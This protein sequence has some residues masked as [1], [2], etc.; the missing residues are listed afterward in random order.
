MLT[1]QE[2]F[3][4]VYN[5]LL[6]QGCK[7]ESTVQGQTICRYRDEGGLACAVGCLIPDKHYRP[8]IEGCGVHEHI[9]YIQRPLIDVLRLSGID[10][11]DNDVLKLI[12]SLQTT[13]DSGD[14]DDWPNTLENTA[15]IHE[16][17]IPE[18]T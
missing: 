1:R 9:E 7:S 2:I 13:H 5:H 18:R 12:S 6:D 8:L 4:K 15:L 16:F 10:T 14:V 3:D 11:D 17:T